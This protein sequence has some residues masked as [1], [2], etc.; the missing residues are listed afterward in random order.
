MKTHI[1]RREY[2]TLD[3]CDVDTGVDIESPYSGMQLGIFEMLEDH[4][5]LY[6]WTTEGDLVECVEN[7]P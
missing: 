1:C 5:R 6:R 4:G 3:E 7:I 2:D